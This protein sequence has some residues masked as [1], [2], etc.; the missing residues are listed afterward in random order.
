MLFLLVDEGDSV[1]DMQELAR[2]NWA[3]RAKNLGI[4]DED[5]NVP[6]SP[7]DLS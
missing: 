7:N 1:T 4:V 2:R 3:K 6:A 5:G